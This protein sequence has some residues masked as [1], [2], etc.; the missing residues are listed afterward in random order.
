MLG[1][2][3]K[4]RS[5]LESAAPGQTCYICSTGLFGLNLVLRSGFD[6]GRPDFEPDVFL[7]GRGVLPVC[8]PAS[9][10]DGRILSRS[11]PTIWIPTVISQ[12]SRLGRAGATCLFAVIQIPNEWL[13]DNLRVGG[14]VV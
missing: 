14:G 2:N 7:G 9:R 6:F 3:E 10:D 11:G 12:C 5:Q 8:G 4:R 1:A 13:A